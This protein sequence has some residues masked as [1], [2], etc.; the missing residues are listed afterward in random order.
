MYLGVLRYEIKALL[1]LFKL[2]LFAVLAQSVT[3]L[4]TVVVEPTGLWRSTVAALRPTGVAG[5]FH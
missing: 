3:A 5:S 1:L 2:L 4:T